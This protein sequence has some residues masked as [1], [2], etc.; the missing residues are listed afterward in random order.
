MDLTRAEVLLLTTVVM[1]PAQKAIGASKTILGLV[2]VGCCALAGFGCSSAP[3][4][5]G[6]AMKICKGEPSTD[7]T[8]R[9]MAAR[10]RG[11][12]AAIAAATSGTATNNPTTGKGFEIVIVPA[13]PAAA[14]MPIQRPANAAI[15]NF[16]LCETSINVMTAMT[17]NTI[18]AKVTMN[19]R[20]SSIYYLENG[21]TRPLYVLP[22]RAS[23]LRVCNRHERR[24]SAYG[25]K[26]TSYSEAAM[27]AFDPKP[28]CGAATIHESCEAG[29]FWWALKKKKPGPPARLL[30]FPHSPEFNEAI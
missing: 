12:A 16:A 24:W 13:D 11:H 6:G 25:T 29:G 26:R 18:S 20:K 27:S 8:P 23:E 30:H 9:V 17:A 3:A 28:R 21:H 5:P 14:A 22:A 7:V 15:V 4:A 10:A 1:S 2:D 19:P